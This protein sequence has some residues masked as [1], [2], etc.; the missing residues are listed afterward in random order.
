MS[1]TRECTASMAKFS[2]IIS[3]QFFEEEHDDSGRAHETGRHK[4]EI[5]FAYEQEKSFVTSSIKDL[6]PVY[7][8]MRHILR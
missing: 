6:L 5:T 2:E 8:T 4:D 1:G 7:D 3:Y